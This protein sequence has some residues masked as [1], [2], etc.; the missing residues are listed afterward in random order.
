MNISRICGH[1]DNLFFGTKEAYFSEQKRFNC[2]CID[3]K[4]LFELSRQDVNKSEEM[5]EFTLN[6][7]NNL[8][9][10]G[11]VYYLAA[12]NTLVQVMRD[13]IGNYWLRRF[14]DFGDMPFMPWIK[15]QDNLVEYLV[16][17]SAILI[18]KYI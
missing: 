5:A 10:P 1:A 2:L 3:C 12:E 9:Q 17:K 8:P 16:S 14:P 15:D 6:L 4:N 11:N 7:D 18:D 13:F